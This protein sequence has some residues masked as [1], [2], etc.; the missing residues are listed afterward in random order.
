M[1]LNKNPAKRLGNGPNG[2]EDIMN[3]SFF[4]GLDW[5]KIYNKEIDPEYIPSLKSQKEFRYFQGQ[6]NFD[7]ANEDGFDLLSENAD[8]DE[9]CDTAAMPMITGFSFFRD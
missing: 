2:I 5:Q 7:C 4:K 1:L 9:H 6:K 3:H 8:I